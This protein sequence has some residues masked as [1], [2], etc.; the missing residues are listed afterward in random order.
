MLHQIFLENTIQDFEITKHVK[1]M[2][3]LEIRMPNYNHITLIIIKVY[4]NIIQYNKY[5]RYVTK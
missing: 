3:T 4:S 1:F 2:T 5:S